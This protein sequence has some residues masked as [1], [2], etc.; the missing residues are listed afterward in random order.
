MRSAYCNLGADDL[1]Y[2]DMG[3]CADL[4][5]KAEDIAPYGQMSAL[6]LDRHNHEAKTL[7]VLIV[8]TT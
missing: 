3:K 7:L 6:G 5:C 8:V 1:A 2:L 4:R